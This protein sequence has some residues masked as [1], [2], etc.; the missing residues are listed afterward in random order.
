MDKKVAPDQSAPIEYYE[1]SAY[2][3][4]S[5]SNHVIKRIEVDDQ[6]NS[7]K[8]LGIRMDAWF[9]RIMLSLR[10]SVVILVIRQAFNF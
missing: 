7:M 1:F 8:L 6:K 3:F 4:E 2:D 9:I 10:A 5:V